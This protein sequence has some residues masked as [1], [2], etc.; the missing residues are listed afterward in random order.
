M[1]F[2]YRMNVADFAMI[3]LEKKFVWG[4]SGPDEFDNTGF[5]YY[6]FKELFSID[7]S[8]NSFGIGESTK[9]MTSSIGNLTK[10]I[11]DDIQKER[12][13]E[14]I[15]V[16]DLVF[17]HTMSLEDNQAT[18]SNQYPGHVGIFLGDKRFIHAN[19]DDGKVVIDELNDIWLKQLVASR[20][21]ISGVIL[22]GTCE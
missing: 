1:E 12:Y 13:L 3:Q 7:L 2:N 4:A 8:R 20:D 17:F 21:I 5:T 14:T 18:A 10:Y 6:I 19:E 22:K 15:K 11:E 9:Q 16:G